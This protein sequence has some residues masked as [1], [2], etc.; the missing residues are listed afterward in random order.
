MTSLI[1]PNI[2]P[3]LVHFAY[4]LTVTAVASYVLAALSP[5]DGWRRTLRPAADWM[6]AFGALAVIATVAAGFQA[7]YTVAHDGPSHEAMTIHRNW[8][9][10]T[11]IG[12]LVLAGWRWTARQNAPSNIFIILSIVGAL[13]ITVT[14]WWGGHIVYNYGIGVKSLPTVT[15]DGHD[16]DHGASK[17]EQAHPSS[18]DTQAST[19]GH[20]HDAGGEP[21]K[22]TD[23]ENGT[24]DT[25]GEGRVDANDGHHDHADGARE[26][27]SS[28]S[29]KSKD[30]GGGHAHDDHS[31]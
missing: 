20:L 18:G 29:D 23:G 31:H 12:I 8:A 27:G 26:G 14:A 17:P 13:S 11:A 4:A 30:E 3:I 21:S 5:A 16:H 6:L 10:P 15:G 25:D 2:H 9:V 7:Y 24:T 1:E 19:D 28:H 22:T